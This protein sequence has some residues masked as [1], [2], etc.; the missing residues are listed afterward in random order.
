ML[1]ITDFKLFRNKLRP[2]FFSLLL[3]FSIN[4]S[5]FGQV[6]QS[7]Y[8]SLGLGGLNWSGYAHNAGM[9]GLGLTY[10]SKFFFNDMNPAI[11]GT[12][13]EAVFQ[14]GAAMDVR[15]ISNGNDAYN[16]FTGGFRD[17]GISLPIVYSKWNVGISV[18]PYSSVNYGFTE[19]RNGPEGSQTLVDVTGSG[20]IDMAS[21]STSFRIG[22]LYLGLR[23]NLHYGNITAE[24]KFTLTDL[25]TNFGTT[26]VNERRSFGKVSG[27]AGL[28]Y[29]I[30]LSDDKFF[31]IGGFYSP[32]FDL[33]QTSLVTFENETSGG[34]VTSSDTLRYD[35]DQDLTVSIPDRYGIGVSYEIAQKFVL[36]VDYQAQNWA[37]Y[38][39]RD[40]GL[41]SYYG[42]AFRF[43]V[44]TE[45]IP[46]Y[47]E[48]SRLLN[49]TS[50]RL[51]FHYE[52]TPFLVNNEQ[53]N[54]IGIN[55]G[56]SVPLSS[57]WGLS[58]VNL[59]ATLGQR[60]NISTAGL[61]REN[62]IKLNLGFS[63][64]DLTWFTKQRF[65]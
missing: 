40:G 27:R 2:L 37:D 10:N 15:S 48:P 9:G 33:G 28:L 62:Y 6:D 3:G 49:V 41:E 56:V 38:R 32:Q 50:F 19:L 42:N 21:L 45:Y 20:G 25:L 17:L 57:F 44:G 51:G 34:N 18:T 1:E 5:S 54:D 4:A 65:N 7:S 13:L 53:V 52:R 58:H 64:Q 35:K 24:E 46:N 23:G 55:F 12:N 63:L 36:G 31:N 39:N 26:V 16:T 29:K 14:L 43:A 22:G 59:G 11:L 61:V 47:E 8:S 60:G 30:K